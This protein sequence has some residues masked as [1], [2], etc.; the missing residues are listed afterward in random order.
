MSRDHDAAVRRGFSLVELLVAI[1]ISGVVL[2]AGYRLFSSQERLGRQQ[3]ALLATQQNL[4]TAHGIFAAD[5]RES[6]GTGGDIISASATHV[7][8]RAMRKAGFVCNRDP[9]NA[10][11]IDVVAVGGTFAVGDSVLIFRD[12]PNVVSSSDDEWVIARVSQV[13][14]AACATSTISPRTQRLTLAAPVASLV[15]AGAPV[16]SFVRVRYAFGTVTGAGGTPVG[17]LYRREAGGDSVPLVFGLLA[18]PQS[19]MKLAYLDSAN[20]V[21][22]TASLPARLSGITQVDVTFGG[23]APGSGGVAR[24]VSDSIRTAIYLRGNR[25]RL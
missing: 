3:G 10:S 18:P 16:R 21:I 9:A 2:T 23:G 13:G 4:R 19:G 17:A 25:R 12:G 7:E 6:S 22:P 24:Q 14:A 20:A 11:W 8:F 5:L 15:W 1:A